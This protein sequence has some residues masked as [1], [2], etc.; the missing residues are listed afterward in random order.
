MGTKA[1][2]KVSGFPSGLIWNDSCVRS[3][4]ESRAFFCKVML[5]LW[6]GVQYVNCL[7]AMSNP[8]SFGF[9]PKEGIAHEMHQ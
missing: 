1:F 2:G 5:A 3:R 4:R 6:L 7:F 9:V 8:E